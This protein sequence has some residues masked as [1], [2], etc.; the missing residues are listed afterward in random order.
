VSPIGRPTTLRSFCTP[1][2]REPLCSRS[3]KLTCDPLP[4]TH[5]PTVSGSKILRLALVVSFRGNILHTHDMCSP[6]HCNHAA[7]F[8]LLC[9]TPLSKII[10]HVARWK[11]TRKNTQNNF[12]LMGAGINAATTGRKGEFIL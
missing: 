1:T 9:E 8:R 3:D 6:A 5:V 4:A 12:K 11:K 7:L 10:G 2:F